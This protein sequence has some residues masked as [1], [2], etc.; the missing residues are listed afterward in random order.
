[1]STR[2]GVWALGISAIAIQLC[3]IP[4]IAEVTP[5]RGPGDPRIRTVAYDPAEVIRLDGYVGYHV[6]LEFAPG[7][8]FVNLGSGDTAGLEVGA[9]GNHL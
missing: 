3:T 8:T 6:H 2:A 1:V 5:P 9:E 4:A 7:E